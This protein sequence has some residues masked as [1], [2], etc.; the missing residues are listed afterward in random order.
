[1][2]I[3]IDPGPT[4]SAIVWY[5]NRKIERADAEVENHDLTRRLR[6]FRALAVSDNS[7]N[8]L[9]LAI[10]CIQH[11]GSGM[12]V[13]AEVFRTCFWI[14]RFIEAEAW[15]GRYVL[16]TRP[17]IK[18]HL[19]GTA[20]AKDPNVRQALID[21]WGGDSVAIGG[22]KCPLCHGKGWRGY[23]HTPCPEWKFPPGPLYGIAT[24]SWAALAVAVTA[25]EVRGCG[26]TLEDE[27]AKGGYAV[28]V[29]IEQKE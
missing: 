1:M 12:P 8:N 13:G 7:D 3:A 23:D 17:T 19:C 29:T 20:T 21:K 28:K 24:H 10:E 27:Q 9:L 14:G 25:A 4:H 5:E 26:F 18:A 16:I 11:Y 15:R 2:I 6:D 22:V